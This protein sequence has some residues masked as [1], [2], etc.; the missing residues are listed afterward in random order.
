[1]P[2]D[3]EN[4]NQSLM[5]QRFIPYPKFESEENSE[6]ENFFKEWNEVFELNG[7]PLNRKFFLLKS[8]LIGKAKRYLDIQDFNT[9]ESL[10]EALIE[11][12]SNKNVNFSVLNC[13]LTN[14]KQHPDEK[15]KDY[16]DRVQRMANK[17]K[18]STIA[19]TEAQVA[20]YFF[21]GLSNK[22]KDPILRVKPKTLKESILLADT[23]EHILSQTLSNVPPKNDP[24]ELLDQ[25]FSLMDGLKLQNESLETHVKDLHDKISPLLD[26]NEVNNMQDVRPK[27]SNNFK[28]K[29][30]EGFSYHNN[31]NKTYPKDSTYSFGNKRNNNFTGREADRFK[32]YPDHSW[33][34]GQRRP[35]QCQI[36]SKFFHTARDC[37]QRKNY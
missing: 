9:F 34:R 11:R 26:T 10:E 24:V 4:I 12:F 6:I 32:S 16:G 2:A 35:V 3:I 33:S 36:C 8:S 7:E 5:L 30:G 17:L 13:A 14:V 21:Q 29:T 25:V 27:S 28:K 1:M 19:P 37:F 20:E 15:V 22:L 23:E 18:K 31:N